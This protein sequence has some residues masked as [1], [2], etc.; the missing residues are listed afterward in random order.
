MEK[1]PEPVETPDFLSAAFCAGAGSV[2]AQHKARQRSARALRRFRAAGDGTRDFIRDSNFIAALSRSQGGRGTVSVGSSL[3]MSRQSRYWP[4]DPPPPVLRPTED[5][6]AAAPADEPLPALGAETA[7]DE[8]AIVP[9]D[10]LE[11]GD[12]TL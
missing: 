5:E 8:T 4:R 2:A 12:G 6:A 11:V 10:P 3:V 7:P 1:A 9:D